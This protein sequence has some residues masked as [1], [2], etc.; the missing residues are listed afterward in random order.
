M[1]GSHSVTTVLLMIAV[2]L[3]W[4]YLFDL[5]E[6]SFPAAHRLLRDART[7][8]IREGRLLR[9]NLKREMIAEEELMAVLREEGGEDSAMVRMACLEADGRISVVKAEAR[10]APGSKRRQDWPE[11]ED[12]GK[13]HQEAMGRPARDAPTD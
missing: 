7:P 10:E 12:T 3:G 4:G 11:E 13:P 9:K 5:L 6:Y 8:L 1:G 2:I